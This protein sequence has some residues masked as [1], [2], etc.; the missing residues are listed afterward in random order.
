MSSRTQ[1]ANAN[2]EIIGHRGHVAL[3]PENTIEG[4]IS[5]LKLGI[6]GIE[7]D[8]VVSADKKVVVSHE[9][10]MRASTMLTP[11]GK[12]IS[13]RQEK[14]FRLYEMTYDSIKKFDSGSL[15]NR[16]FKNQKNFP[17]Y[18]PLL[19]EVF[20]N[21]ENYQQQNDLQPLQYYLEIKS[22]P[23]EYDLLQPQ[24]EEFVNLVMELVTAKNLQQRVII[25]SFDAAILE[26]VKERS[27]EIA[28]SYLLYKKDIE[29]SLQLA[30]FTPNIVSP[31]FKQLRGPETVVSLQERGYKVVP[32]TVNRTSQ[33]KKMINLGVDGI[34]TD[35]PE[36]VLKTK[37]S[38]E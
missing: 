38:L 28:I 2:V 23:E 7:L 15:N 1:F 14:D 8:L 21:L 20:E 26:V 27:P 34:I 36:R 31:Y 30:S 22:S 32:W 13:K 9:P 35:Y 17:A 19:E 37:A 5:A 6:D 12:R 3:Y 11:Q 4:F 24:P 10:Y 33:I 29:E 25:S 18:K 16:K